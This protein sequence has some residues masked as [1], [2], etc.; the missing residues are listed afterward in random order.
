MINKFRKKTGKSKKHKKSIDLVKDLF[1]R[2][3]YYIIDLMVRYYILT[4]Y[5][6]KK[7]FQVPFLSAGIYLNA[8]FPKLSLSFL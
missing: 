5:C 2:N 7:C 4:L 8:P 6:K 1:F 3:C